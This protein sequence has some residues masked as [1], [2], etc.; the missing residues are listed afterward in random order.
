[1]FDCCVFGGTFV[2]VCVLGAP[3]VVSA[4]A[5]EGGRAASIIHAPHPMGAAWIL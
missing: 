3:V 5:T 2:L 4:F 1:M